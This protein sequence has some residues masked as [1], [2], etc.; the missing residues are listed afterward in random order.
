MLK[1]KKW[2]IWDWKFKTN[3]LFLLKVKKPIEKKGLGYSAAKEIIYPCYLFDV[4]CEKELY[5]SAFR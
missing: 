5:T 3:W 2:M 1:L 4:E